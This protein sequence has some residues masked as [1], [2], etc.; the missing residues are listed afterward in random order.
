VPQRLSSRESLL[1]IF[2]EEAFEKTE[3]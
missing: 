3:P 2:F 1:R